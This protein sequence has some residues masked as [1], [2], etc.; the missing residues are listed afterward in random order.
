MSRFDNNCLWITGGFDDGISVPTFVNV[1]GGHSDLCHPL[2][3]IAL[4]P[5]GAYIASKFNPVNLF[6]SF[7]L[8]GYNACGASRQRQRKAKKSSKKGLHSALKAVFYLSVTGI[9]NL[10]FKKITRKKL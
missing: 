9:V 7:K 4:Y 6:H 2:A 1:I 10:W 3:S 8:L 5:D